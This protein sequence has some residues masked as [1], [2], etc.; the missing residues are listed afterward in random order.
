MW[1]YGTPYIMM[2]HKDVPF[3]QGTHFTA[4]EMQ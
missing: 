2:F 1:N 4:N 3:Y